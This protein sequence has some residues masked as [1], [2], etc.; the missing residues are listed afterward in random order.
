MKKIIYIII[1]GLLSGSGLTAQNLENIFASILKNN[2][3]ILANNYYLNKL[4]IQVKTGLSL[5]NPSVSYEYLW[6]K[7]STTKFAQ[8]FEISQGFKF[9]TSYAYK[10]TISNLEIE[11]TVYRRSLFQLEI[12]LETKLVCVEI[13]HLNKKKLELNERLNYAQQLVSNLQSKLNNGYTTQFE[14]DKAKISE[15]SIQNEVLQLESQ[16]SQKT[17]HLTELNG[18]NV[19]TITETEYL[20][21]TIPS[22]FDVLFE[23]I[24][25]ID[26]LKKLIEL[27]ISIAELDVKLT[28]TGALPD[29]QIGYK[30][31]RVMSDKLVGIHLGMSI[32]LWENKNKVKESIINMDHMKSN[33]VDHKNEHFFLTKSLFDEFTSSKIRL[34]KF[35]D[36]WDQL[37]FLQN[38]EKAL[39]EGEISSTEY[40]IELKLMYEI[41][42]NLLNI[43]K[44]YQLQLTHLNKYE[45]LKYL[46]GQVD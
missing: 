2:K 15:L 10:N 28:R 38:I 14:L 11:K 37:N 17:D 33:I 30:S 19:I 32:P 29:F 18:G 40:F 41:K 7:N 45:L 42:D 5:N 43:E 24:E 6:D 22:S 13:I 34:E 31:E 20:V 26:P 4:N 23:H 27:E 12:L 36:L 21:Q 44:D 1:I 3:S 8:E 35:Q 9:P 39:E 46:S 25:E 16:L